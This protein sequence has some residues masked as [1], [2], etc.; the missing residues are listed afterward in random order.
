V[1]YNLGRLYQDPP[2]NSL[3]LIGKLT[4]E[5]FLAA[6]DTRAG[7]V[8]HNTSDDQRQALSYY[9]QALGLAREEK[10]VIVEASCLINIA[11]AHRHLGEWAQ[12][13]RYIEE[14]GPVVDRV[15]TPMCNLMRKAL[16]DEKRFQA[17]RSGA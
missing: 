10:R 8:H 7:A 15:G 5:E 16:A 3:F 1:L 17:E 2:R 12:H 11:V 9:H 14:A 6:W 4:G 13:R